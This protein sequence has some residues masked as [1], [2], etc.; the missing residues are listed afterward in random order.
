MFDVTN[1]L[2]H[3]RRN[4]FHTSDSFLRKAARK[5]FDFTPVGRAVKTFQGFFPRGGGGPSPC[6]AGQRRTGRGCITPRLTTVGTLREHVGSRPLTEGTNLPITRALH[7]GHGHFFTAAQATAAAG[8]VGEAVMGR[9][10]AGLVAE[11]E[12]RLMHTCLPGMVL[13]D[14][15]ICY[16]KGQVPNKRRMWPKGRKPLLTGGEMNAITIAARAARRVKSTTKKLQSLGMLERP[17]P[18]LR[19]KPLPTTR[20]IAGPSIINVE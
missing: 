6:P 12:T 17:R 2:P 7:E 3:E 16:N 9:Y 15:G 5:A 13:G 14:D 4:F 11:E 20:Q 19:P 8:F 10:G 18:R 1:S